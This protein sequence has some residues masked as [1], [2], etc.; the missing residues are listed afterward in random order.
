MATSAAERIANTV[1]DG[2][3]DSY[4]RE[5]GPF[6]P[7]T[8]PYWSEQAD[9]DPVT[10]EVIRHKLFGVV[11]EQGL[12]ITK[13]SGSPVA[14]FA[15]DFSTT[16]LSA[17]GEIVYFGP[18]NQP[19]VGHIDRNV[20]W[21]LE[22]RAEN[23][24]I[25]DG[26]M[27]L[28]NDPW[29]GANHQSDVIIICPV[30]WEGTLLC[31]VASAIHT[32][33]VG[34]S[35]PGGFCPDAESVYDEPLPTPPVAYVEDGRIRADAEDMFL[36]RSRLPDL[37]RLDLR[38]LIASN[39]VAKQ[40]MI[41]LVGRYGVSTI[42]ASMTKVIDDS[43]RA[44]QSRLEKLRDGSWS[45]HVYVDIAGPGDRGLYPI[46][47]TLR[48]QGDQLIF[49]NNGTHPQAGALNTT[50]GGWR[51]SI[52]SAVN[53][54]LCFDLMYAMGGPMRRMRFD[55]VPGTVVSASYP[56]SVSN[57]SVGVLLGLGLGTVCVSKMLASAAD[58]D[59]RRR[60]MGTTAMMFPVSTI[61]GLDRDGTAY[62]TMNL[63]PMGGGLGALPSRDGVD[64]GG[65]IWDPVSTMP[66]VEFV[67]QEFP[68]LYLY[69]R[70][71]ADSGGAGAFRGGNG[72]VFALTPHKV[73]GLTV[74]I[75]A[76]GWALPLGAG[77]LGGLPAAANGAQ[78]AGATN[79]A[80]L[81]A[82]GKVPRAIADVGGDLVPLPPKLR[83]HDLRAGDM[84]ELWW[85]GGGGF[86]DP[87]SRDPAA[88]AEDVLQGT[89]S[90]GQARAV[91]GVV[92]GTDGDADV[93]ATAELRRGLGVTDAGSGVE[94]IP[95]FEDTDGTW[96][97]P[98]CDAVL[99]SNGEGHLAHT[100]VADTTIENLTPVNRPTDLFV[101]PEVRF[102]THACPGCGR[103]IEGYVTVPSVADLLPRTH[104]DG[105]FTA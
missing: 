24:G 92:V 102:R 104:L 34:G 63:D 94:P 88:V 35:T 10:F 96:H 103:R 75:S 7:M 42:V 105:D 43:E 41:E 59:L 36:R 30:F 78:S 64:T 45:H 93:T 77:L 99:G 68:I 89:V 19:Q 52:L 21:V 83:N 37:L 5:E 90:A 71:L 56:G 11:E 60:A 20:K 95:R 100:V 67:E 65:H 46:C 86:G 38:A 14:T 91:Y 58:P 40:R 47:L 55:A 4:V 32:V 13:V 22:H 8:V 82:A 29:I 39:N 70:E 50:A 16:L 18:W 80:G 31:W 53:S 73:P 81:F 74:D 23:P 69:R 61:S 25:R 97:C 33:D 76:S 48:K 2:T 87:L 49:D 15:H 62:G 3:T 57:S 44:F 27:F 28:G 54:L 51:S 101:D 26:H 79:L 85:N 1:W 9:L 72:G 84:F 17:E 12:T 66:N 98:N 6:A